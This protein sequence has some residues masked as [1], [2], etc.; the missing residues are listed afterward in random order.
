MTVIVKPAWYQSSLFY[1]C[2]IVLIVS[3]IVYA[4]II[5][6]EKSRKEIHRIETQ[7]KLDI[8]QIRAESIA[9]R[10]MKEK[11]RELLM[12]VVE[13]I[14]Q[15][16]EN[17]EFGVQELAEALEMSRSNLNIR[18][19]AI[20][21][22]TPLEIIRKIRFEKAYKMLL[23]GNYKINEVASATGFTSATYFTYNF[24]KET[25]LTP[26]QW[27]SQNKNI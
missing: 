15:N 5:Q 1:A 27:V 9:V 12:N 22:V 16:I 8:S 7:A 21:D 17:A 25:G 6:E 11:D 13:T 2:I 14:D 19:K 10:P 24:R 3:L 20:T 26:S 23:S 18:I 4:F